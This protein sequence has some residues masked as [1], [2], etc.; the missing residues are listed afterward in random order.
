MEIE[1][2]FYIDQYNIYCSEHSRR[3]EYA[4]KLDYGGV[5]IPM[6]QECIDELYEAILPQV[7]AE[8][9]DKSK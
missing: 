6:C 1:K 4:V 3:P 7:S 5:I 2:D 9:R 8:V